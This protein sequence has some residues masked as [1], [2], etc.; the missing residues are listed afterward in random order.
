MTSPE[1]V[2]REVTDQSTAGNDSFINK[3]AREVYVFGGGTLGGALKEAHDD[4]VK[5]PGQAALKVAESI[6]VGA[7]FAAA[8][9]APTPIKIGARVLGTGL[10]AHFFSDLAD[11]DRWQGLGSVWSNTW[12]SGADTD[13]NFAKVQGS[14][15]RLTLESGVMI[16]GAKLGSAGIGK[17][18]DFKFG[19]AKEVPAEIQSTKASPHDVAK[20]VLNGGL[21]EMISHDA[22][23]WNVARSSAIEKG[24]L[25]SKTTPANEAAV[26]SK[27]YVAGEQGNAYTAF[28]RDRFGTL[29][30]MGI[31]LPVTEAAG[32]AASNPH[33]MEL[34]VWQRKGAVIAVTNYA[35]AVERA[36]FPFGRVEKIAPALSKSE[37]RTATDAHFLTRGTASLEDIQSAAR[38]HHATIGNEGFSAWQAARNAFA[39]IKPGN[40]T[41]ASALAEQLVPELFSAGFRH[42]QMI[43]PAIMRVA[44]ESFLRDPSLLPAA[45][46]SARILPRATT[47]ESVGAIKSLLESGRNGNN[48][49]RT[50]ITNL[51]RGAAVS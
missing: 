34:P 27:A 2:E 37:V 29:S 48:I 33:V 22:A 10:M 18:V 7:A 6:G 41:E 46:V 40:P 43:S 17:A 45:A 8:E 39:G 3:V 11:K 32:A 30:D 14:L 47:H 49:T 21:A 28:L 42:D 25:L 38:V 50:D 15:G 35:H 1:R 36:Q 24:G 16:A 23:A 31:P 4:V 13:Q 20:L 9:F 51:L 5:N 19:A 44:A 26:G 12:K